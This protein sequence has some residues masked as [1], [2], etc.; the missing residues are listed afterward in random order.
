MIYQTQMIQISLGLKLILM[1]WFKK[2]TLTNDTTDKIVPLS[3]LF[4]Q[5]F[6]QLQ[7]FKSDRFFELTIS[8]ILDFYSLKL[9]FECYIFTLPSPRLILNTNMII[10][11]DIN[12]IALLLFITFSRSSCRGQKTVKYTRHMYIPDILNTLF[13]FHS[14][15]NFTIE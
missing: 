8:Q 5:S 3:T 2:M 15:F 11:I 4:P 10:Q 9:L 6:Q 1:F 12:Y 7:K 14:V 13:C